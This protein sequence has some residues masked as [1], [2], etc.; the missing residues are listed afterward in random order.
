MQHTLKY[1]RHIEVVNL[2]PGLSQMSFFHVQKLR[3]KT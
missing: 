1:G 2:S 3:A